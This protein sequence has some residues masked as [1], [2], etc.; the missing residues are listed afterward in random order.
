MLTWDESKRKA[1]IAKH[2]YDFVG[3]DAVF[4]GFV[5]AE[6]DARDAYGEQ[7]INLLGLLDG[8]VVH[9][10]YADDGNI[11]RAI[12]LRKATKRE[13]HNYLQALTS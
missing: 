2:G 11:I 9:L 6:E 8:V 1:N 10:T 5:L 12:S 4:D 3:A 7:R 13:T